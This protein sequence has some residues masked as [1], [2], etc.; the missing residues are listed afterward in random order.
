MYDILALFLN[1]T[2][3][4]LIRSVV[5]HQTLKVLLP[6]MVDMTNNLLASYPH[7]EKVIFVTKWLAGHFG[8]NNYVYSDPS[9]YRASPIAASRNFLQ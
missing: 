8:R 4:K 6:I 7:V 9:L 5:L 3:C 1:W 2:L